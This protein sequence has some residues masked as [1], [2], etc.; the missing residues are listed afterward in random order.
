[1]TTRDLGLERICP[2]LQGSPYV[3][4]SAKDPRYNCVAFA[5]GDVSQFWYDV[6]IN[7]YY[8]PPGARS[9]DTI[10]GWTDVFEIHGYRETVDRSLELDYEKIAIYASA[11]G[12]EHVA[13]QRASGMWTSKA[14][15]GRDFEHELEWLEGD[16]YGKVAKIMKRKCQSGKRVL[17]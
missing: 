15:K 16:F 7:G 11:D 10:E 9:A 12:P 8:W 13:R 4:T 5:V 1:M 17:E 3:L 14:G 2:N 6:S